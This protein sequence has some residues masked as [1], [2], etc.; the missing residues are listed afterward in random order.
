MLHEKMSS[1]GW[2]TLVLLF[3][4]YSNA[5]ECVPC[6]PAGVPVLEKGDFVFFSSSVFSKPTNDAEARRRGE[7]SA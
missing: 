2:L 5:A 7:R 1:I 4:T 6:F 3:G